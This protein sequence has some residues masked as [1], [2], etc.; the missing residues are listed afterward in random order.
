MHPLKFWLQ[1]EHVETL[2]DLKYL[3]VLAYKM[4][5]IYTISDHFNC[6]TVYL[7]AITASVMALVSHKD[8]F[9]SIISILYSVTCFCKDADIQSSFGETKTNN[10]WVYVDLDL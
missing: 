6:T 4:Y 2:L 9:P 5:I 7:R 10:M 1:P 3:V 8:S